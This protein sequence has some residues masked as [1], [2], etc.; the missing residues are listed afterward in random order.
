MVD[1]TIPAGAE[2]AAATTSS[3]LCNGSLLNNIIDDFGQQVVIRVVTQNSDPNDAYNNEAPTTTDYRTIAFANLYTQT[4]DEVKEG[5]FEGGTVILNFKNT[6]DE[7]IQTGN[8]VWYDGKWFEISSVI[9]HPAREMNF[10][11]QATVRRA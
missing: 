6:D 8:L 9:R 1:K 10:L 3:I 2:I 5:I 4:D 7:Y 11:I